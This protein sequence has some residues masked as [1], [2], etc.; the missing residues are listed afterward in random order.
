MQLLKLIPHELTYKKKQTFFKDVTFVIL[1]KDLS[2]DISVILL[3]KEAVP[4]SGYFILVGTA[5]FYKKTSVKLLNL[6]SPK[7]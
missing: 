3:D 2:F 4:W 7:F 5:I 6:T 1:F